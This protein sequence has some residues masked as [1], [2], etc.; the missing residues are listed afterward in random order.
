MR[1]LYRFKCDHAECNAHILRTLKHVIQQYKRKWAKELIELLMEIANSIKEAMKAGYNSLRA[2]DILKFEKKFDEIIKA[3]YQEYKDDPNPN[4]DYSGEDMKL[5]R[6]LDKYR[7]N[8]LAFMYDF[9]I[10]MD[11]NLAERDLRMIKAKKKISGCFRSDKAGEAYTDIK[12][13]LSTMRKQGENLF[14]AL[15]N[16]FNNKPKLL[17]Y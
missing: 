16:A 17:A 14:N 5:L 1:G 15:L 8:H 7:D 3:G 6:R 13:Y 11:N 10:P 9:R 12:S 4:K 2:E